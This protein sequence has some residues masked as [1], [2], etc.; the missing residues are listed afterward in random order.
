ML[1]GLSGVNRGKSPITKAKYGDKDHTNTGNVDLVAQETATKALTG[2]QS[3]TAAEPY[4]R[5]KTQPVKPEGQYAGPGLSKDVRPPRLGSQHT[6]KTKVNSSSTPLASTSAEDSTL[7][8]TSLEDFDTKPKSLAGKRPQSITKVYEYLDGSA[9][10]RSI[11]LGPEPP[12]TASNNTSN[13]PNPRK[14]RLQQSPVNQPATPELVTMAKHQAAIKAIKDAYDKQLAEERAQALIREQALEAEK[15]S[16]V[17]A[18]KLDVEKAK[19]ECQEERQDL[20]TRLAAYQVKQTGH[21]VDIQGYKIRIA[22]LQREIDS[23]RSLVK[24]TS[25]QKEVE[26]GT[27][28]TQIQGYGH[29]FSDLTELFDRGLETIVSEELGDR[30]VLNSKAMAEVDTLRTELVRCEAIAEANYAYL[31]QQKKEL[32]KQVD[33]TR[34]EREKI[35]EQLNELQEQQIRFKER[36]EKRIAEYEEERN[37]FRKQLDVSGHALDLE[38]EVRK[39]AEEKQRSTEEEYRNKIAEER[40]HKLMLEQQIEERQ[41]ILEEERKRRASL[42]GKWEEDKSNLEYERQRRA[43]LQDKY[44]EDRLVMENHRAVLESNLSTHKSTLEEEKA[45]RA[46]LEYKWEEEQQRKIN[47]ERERQRRIDEMREMYTPSPT[48]KSKK[49]RDVEPTSP[50]FELPPVS[51]GPASLEEQQQKALLEKQRLMKLERQ[52]LA[53]QHQQLRIKENTAKHLDALSHEQEE[54]RCQSPSMDSHGSTFVALDAST[55]VVDAA[56]QEIYADQSRSVLESQEDVEHSSECSMYAAIEVSYNAIESMVSD[57]VAGVEEKEKKKEVPELNLDT[58]SRELDMD[59]VATDTQKDRELDMAMMSPS[60]LDMAMMSPSNRDFSTHPP[61][62]FGPANLPEE[63][64]KQLEERNRQR[65]LELRRLNQE[66]QLDDLAR[67][68]GYVQS[69]SQNSHASSDAARETSSMF[70]DNLL[71]DIQADAQKLDDEE[72]QLRARHM[73]EVSLAG[74]LSTVEV[75]SQSASDAAM[76]NGA[77]LVNS[78]LNDIQAEEQGRGEWGQVQPCNLDEASLAGTIEGYSDS[79]EA[80]NS[81]MH[82]VDNMLTE[83]EAEARRHDEAN[84]LR[85]RQMEEVS[86]AGSLSQVD[87]CSPSLESTIMEAVR[88]AGAQIVDNTVQDLDAEELEKRRLSMQRHEYEALLAQ[89]EEKKKVLE[90]QEAKEREEL[91]K[92]QEAKEAEDR[93]QEAKEAKERRKQLEEQK[94]Q[95]EALAHDRRLAQVEAQLQQLAEQKREANVLAQDERLAQ[96]ETQL[97]EEKTARRAA[98]DEARRK[99][100]AR[101]EL[102]EQLISER[103][104]LLREIAKDKARMEEEIANELAKQKIR[105]QEEAAAKEKARMEQEIADELAKAKMRLQEEEAARAKKQQ[106][107]EENRLQAERREKQI[108]D[109]HEKKWQTMF[110][111]THAEFTKSFSAQEAKYQIRNDMLEGELKAKEQQIKQLKEQLQ[112]KEAAYEE[113]LQSKESELQGRIQSHEQQLQTREIEFEVK[114][115]NKESE[116]KEHIDAHEKKV[117]DVNA[118]WLQRLSEHQ[119]GAS[120]KESQWAKDLSDQLAALK[121]KDYEWS[122]R[123]AG[124][125][126]EVKKKDAEWMK[127]LNDVKEERAVLQRKLMDLSGSIR[128]EIGYDRM[129]KEQTGMLIEDQQS[130]MLALWETNQ[131]QA[132]ELQTLRSHAMVST[133]QTTEVWRTA[134]SAIEAQRE[135]F[136]KKVVEAVEAT[137]KQ[138]EDKFEDGHYQ[139]E[140]ALHR[141]IHELEAEST[142]QKQLIKS[143]LEEQADT[144]LR[145]RLNH[146]RLAMK[147]EDYLSKA[148]EYQDYGYVPRFFDRGTALCGIARTLVNDTYQLISHKQSTTYARL[149]EKDR[150]MFKKESEDIYSKC[151]YRIEILEHDLSETKESLQKCEE[152]RKKLKVFSLQPTTASGRPAAAEGAGG[153][154]ASATTRS[155]KNKDLKGLM[156]DFLQELLKGKKM[157]LVTEG[158]GSMPCTLSI[159]KD[160]TALSLQ[161]MYKTYNIPMSE[162][163]HVISGKDVPPNVWTSTPVDDNSVTILFGP[164][165]E[166]QHTCC[167]RVET[168]EERDKFVNSMRVLRL[169]TVGNEKGSSE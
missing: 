105:F 26:V 142:E 94:R 169:S 69:T 112:N 66:R 23:A 76:E 153:A 29:T 65:Q 81:P 97:Q 33:E 17:E 28:Q 154:S 89:E 108:Q 120:T 111:E 147:A 90:E 95:E 166:E 130:H 1:F 82:I 62:S 77:T 150:D 107:E 36:T 123:L 88:E 32:H 157:R 49:N 168:I 52:R 145:E 53:E 101:K 22:D 20:H 43:S 71:H 38:K 68:D 56:V 24:K 126:A 93:K 151:K 21:D 27:L 114:L 113:R 162:I 8:S 109:K 50:L 116:L 110:E 25:E 128:N 164:S 141:D 42:Q 19:H 9:H 87:C 96:K 146:E 125:E 75:C 79:A 7:T 117:E 158:G 3:Q 92:Q 137:K 155:I 46:S 63:K 14:K 11:E 86:L 156:R 103:Q 54:V 102:E 133:T 2:T 51:L 45:R 70:V 122:E 127:R 160:L 165:T 98:E 161:A 167:F 5:L 40:Q 58:V 44:N 159:A 39:S 83:V 61:M 129:M 148:W 144:L 37:F 10:D 118:T 78:M 67:E 140:L 30:L 119:A 121:T 91:K 13:K 84:P 106:E 139:K 85:T 149:L 35:K 135:K 124:K 41:R 47:L 6:G 73:E 15:Q 163:Q 74:S 59:L 132:E 104:S 60:N 100:L 18:A 80:Q 34:L 12:K 143:L 55:Y 16:L 48:N 115:Q 64:Q 134:N 57:A 138:Y 136:E 31:E 99:S 72:N 4:R 152:E 131:Q